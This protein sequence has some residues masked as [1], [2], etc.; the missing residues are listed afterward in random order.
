MLNIFNQIITENSANIKQ[1]IE[2]I[3]GIGG[4]LIVVGVIQLF[5]WIVNR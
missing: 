5:N 3:M 4:M 1:F 2:I